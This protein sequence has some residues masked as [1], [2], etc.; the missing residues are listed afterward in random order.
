MSCITPLCSTNTIS[1][2]YA[3]LFVL[4]KIAY[5]TQS[6]VPSVYTVST[7]NHAFGT[8]TSSVIALP[9]VGLT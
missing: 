2:N 9:K 7:A 8:S 3:V 6:F 4:Q 5:I 1:A